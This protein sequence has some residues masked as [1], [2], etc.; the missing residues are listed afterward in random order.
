M[1][2]TKVPIRLHISRLIFVAKTGTVLCDLASFL[3]TTIPFNVDSFAS[4]ILAAME[5]SDPSS[6]AG[7]LKLGE[8]SLFEQQVQIY[9]AVV[10][11]SY[12]I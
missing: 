2:Y 5:L 7:N 4:A 8:I 3:Y 12:A 11:N 10:D 1:E 9:Y 6:S